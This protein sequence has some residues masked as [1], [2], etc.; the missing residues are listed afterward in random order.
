MIPIDLKGRKAL[1][2]GG[3]SG[4]G[5][6]TAKSL[7][8]AGADIAIAYRGGSRSRAECGCRGAEIRRARIDRRTGRCL[9]T[10][11]CGPAVFTGW[12]RNSAAPTY[13]S[14]MPA[15]MAPAR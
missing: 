11:R 9:Q 13:S 5:A 8:E 7:A 10:G 4:L 6:A 2:T 3:D 12:T 1:I 14:T 15:W